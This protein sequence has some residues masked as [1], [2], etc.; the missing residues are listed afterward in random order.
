MAGKIQETT[1]YSKVKSH[2]NESVAH[3]N[4]SIQKIASYD[5][6]QTLA[7]LKRRTYQ[8]AVHWVQV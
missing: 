5:L 2:E 1:Q 6:T 4:N 8:T 3:Y 7:S